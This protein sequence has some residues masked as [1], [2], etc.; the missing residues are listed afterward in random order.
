[1]DWF[2]KVHSPKAAPI[3]YDAPA[4]SAPMIIVSRLDKYHLAPVTK[5]FPKPKMNKN[6]IATNDVI[7][8]K[9]LFIFMSLALATIVGIKGKNPKKQK[10]K[11]VTK[12]FLKGFSSSGIS[13]SY[14]II[15]TFKNPSLFLL[16]IW[17]ISSDTSG[18]SPI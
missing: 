16:K 6:R 8:I 10:L 18:F 14:S 9:L 4:D 5:L 13:W 17:T 1:M 7:Q 11:K 2:I 12:L 15:M 3:P